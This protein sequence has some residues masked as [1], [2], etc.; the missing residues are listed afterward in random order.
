MTVTEL[1]LTDFRNYSCAQLQFDPGANLIIGQNAQGKTNLLEAVFLCAVTR[2]FR[3]AKESELVRFGAPKYRVELQAQKNDRLIALAVEGAAG[4]KRIWYNEVPQKKQAD[5]LGKL[6]AVL[7]SP[8]HLNLVKDGPAE[9]RRFL[10]LTLCQFYP[11]YFT[12]LARYNRLLQQKAALLKSEQPD[13]GMLDVLNEQLATFG[14]L[15]QQYRADHCRKLSEKAQRIHLGLSGGSEELALAYQ[16]SPQGQSLLERLRA[17]AER[18]LAAG[19]CLYGPHR[20]DFE[21][22]I[23]G[24]PARVYASQGQQ[25]SAVLS[26]KI[27]ECELFYDLFGEQPVLL[28]DDVLSE[29]DEKRRDYILN[30]IEGKQVLMTCCDL[31]HSAA[32]AR[33]QVFMVADGRVSRKVSPQ[34]E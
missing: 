20:D 15:I 16:P 24:V 25:R 29:L 18:E 30:H 19:L 3:G 14:S 27:A 11:A 9:R 26:M 34:K 23:G 13:R 1:R 2:S 5:L 12:A 21:V 8:D 33:G 10:D 32:L 4:A 6:L 22:S 28:L 17:A 31:Q 7:F